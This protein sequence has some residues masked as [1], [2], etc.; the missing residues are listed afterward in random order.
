[1]KL[2]ASAIRLK[3]ARA[4]TPRSA[5]SARRNGSSAA[6]HRLAGWPVKLARFSLMNT[7]YAVQN[8]VQTAE[9]CRKRLQ[10]MT[11]GSRCA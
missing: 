5:D 6:M 11:C 1:M 4:A 10:A 3:G 2:A 8:P 7:R 9:L